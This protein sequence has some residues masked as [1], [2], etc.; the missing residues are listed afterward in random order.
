LSWYMVSI[1]SSRNIRS[2]SSITST[3]G[4]FFFRIELGA[5]IRGNIAII[6]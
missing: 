4:D 1:M 5:V 2:S 6:V 3:G